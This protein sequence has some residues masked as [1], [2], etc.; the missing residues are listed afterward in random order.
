MTD[1]LPPLAMS[2][3]PRFAIT[4]ALLAQVEMVAALRERIRR[5]AVQVAWIPVLQ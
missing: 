1:E 2:Y 4:P 3:R 5:A